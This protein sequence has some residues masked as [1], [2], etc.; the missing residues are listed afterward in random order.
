MGVRKRSVCSQGHSGAPVS[1]HSVL[2]HPSSLWSF[3]YPC[4]GAQWHLKQGSCCHE[5]CHDPRSWDLEMAEVRWRGGGWQWNMVMVEDGWLYP[6]S[7][8]ATHEFKG[9]VDC[10]Q[11]GW[12]ESF[13]GDPGPPLGAM[14]TTIL[15]WSSHLSFPFKTICKNRQ[16]ILSSFGI[17]FSFL[18][19]F[20]RRE[21]HTFWLACLP[22]YS[23]FKP[24]R[25]GFRPLCSV[26]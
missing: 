9:R 26:H 19:T 24:L 14:L 3:P 23:F 16:W 7:P 11:Q 12:Q 6:S 20:F 4:S 13:G 15:L 8:K 1:L 10:E 22:S 25:P 5:C 17:L 18:I 2:L 21:I